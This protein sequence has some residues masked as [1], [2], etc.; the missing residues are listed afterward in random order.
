MKAAVYHNNSDIRIEE[1]PVPEIGPGEMLVRIAASG[2]CGSDVM[3][4][5]R[6]K[7]APLVLG[8]EIAGTI[9]KVG[10]GV[11]R[12]RVSERVFASHHVP[13]NTCRYCLAGQHTVC[14]TLHTTNFDPGGFAEFVRLPAI[15]VDRGVLVLPDGVS[16]EEGTFVEPL[17][18]VLRGQRIAG[19]EPG[20]TVAVLGSGISG[21]LHIA[22]A[23]ALGVSR[24]IATD[25]NA[26][27][28]QQAEKFGATAVLHGDDAVPKKI[29]ENNLGRAADV[30]I[31]CAGSLEVLAQALQSVDRGG[32]LLFFATP[33]PGQD[34]PVPVNDFWRNGVTLVPSYAGAPADCAQA[35]ELIAGRAVPVADMITHRL[36]LEKIQQGFDLVASGEE[37]L[38]VI[39]EP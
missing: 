9:E 30:V 20:K 23:R 26:F 15:N 39:V 28:M 33:P 7:K 27:R 3:E 38:K 2:I 21:I 13:C 6:V 1:Q 25:I 17:A 32:T 12:Y 22:L 14:Q 19:V 31:V 11:S 4:W 8:H 18:C 34:L 29:R 24:V 36:P 37:S 5:Y 16:F 10:P 35:L